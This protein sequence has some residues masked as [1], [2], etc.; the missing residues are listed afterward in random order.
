M[1]G[2]R[3][4]TGLLI[5]CL[6]ATAVAEAEV[7]VWTDANGR[8]HM[9]DDLSQVPPAQRKK[10][11]AAGDRAASSA[12]VQQVDTPQAP[13]VRSRAPK[14][15]AAGLPVPNALRVHV[16]EVERAGSSMR[17]VATLNGRVNVPF[18]V[19]TGAEVCTLPSWALE[20]L[21]IEVDESTPRMSLTG[22]GGTVRVPVVDVEEV[23]LGG[24]TV[25]NVQMAVVDSMPMGLLCLPFFNHFR[26]STD[27]AN[28]ILRLEEIDGGEGS[29]R[30][31]FRTRRDAL[32]R[33]R[34]KR[35]ATPD[36]SVA[37]LADLDKQQRYWEE[38]LERL[39]SQATR[40]GVPQEWRE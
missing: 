33:I 21:G 31:A 12:A 36:E 24:A 32:E 22:V 23:K 25:Q 38:Q 19:D 4:A 28:G 3:A 6:W 15:P 29:W 5:A 26:V 2:A 40:L 39:E 1:S 20:P 14:D 18:I 9:T 34:Q 27:P 13:L 11:E 17:V 7:F 37:M 10:A 30:E 8:V 16:L 35:E